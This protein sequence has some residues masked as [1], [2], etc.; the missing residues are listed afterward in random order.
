M[1][2]EC[3]EEQRLGLHGVAEDVVVVDVVDFEAGVEDGGFGW[4]GVVFL[5]VAG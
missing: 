5:I 1:Y 4:G 2:F 3:F